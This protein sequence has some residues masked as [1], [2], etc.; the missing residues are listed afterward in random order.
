MNG[1]GVNAMPPSPGDVVRI[2]TR[3][4]LVEDVQGCAGG[5][6]IRGA[7]LDDD[8]QG[9]TLHAIWEL[10]LDTEILDEDAWKSIGQRGFDSPRYFGAY[11]HTLRWN[12]VTATNPRLFQAPFRA[13]IRIDAYQLDPLRKALLLPRVNLFIADDVG[14]GKTIEAGL[15]ASE[16]LLRRRVRDIV[17]SC[18]PSMLLQWKD[19]LES[20]FG[21]TFEVLD[22]KYLEKVRQERG[23]GVNPWTTFPRFLISQRLLIDETYVAPLRDWLDNFRPGSLLILD[24]AHHAAPSSGAKYAIDSRITRAVRDLAPRF[25][26]R[27]FLS[28]TPHNGHSNSFS[29][30]LEI[31]DS[32]RF[33]RGV[34]VLK[35]NL[36]SVMVRRLKEDVREVAGG[37]PKRNVVQVDL[38]KDQVPDDAPELVLPKLL[39][40]YRLV[41]QQ[42]MEGASKRKQAEAGLLI[43]GLQQR[44][45]SSVEA[46]TKTL[47]VH[48]RTM[49]RLWTQD[50]TTQNSRVTTA[51]G[52]TDLKQLTLLTES[53]SSDD[54]LSQLGEQDLEALE[55]EQFEAATVSTAGD[56][57]RA[58]VKAEKELLDKMLAVA[59]Q[60]RGLPDARIRYLVEWIREHMCPGVHLPGERPPSDNPR[61]NDL[62]LLIFTEWEDTKRYLVNMLR[63]AVTGTDLEEHRIEIFHGP[64]PPKKREKIKRAFN[65]PP[66][67]HPVRILVATDAAREGLNLQAH[68]HHLFHFDVPWNP[69]RLE[70][71]NGRIDRK[72]QPAPEVFCHYFVY[73]QR[74]E[75]R[76]LQVLVRKTKTI[77]EELGSLSEVLEAR[78]ADML[79]GGIHHNQVQRLADEIDKADLDSE[80]RATTEEELDVT[81][82]RQD[83]L[84][85]QIAQLDRRVAEARKWIGLD[86][87]SLRDA[88]SCSLEMLGAE[89]LQSQKSPKG[90]PARFVFPNLDTR[91]GGDP[92]WATTLDTLRALPLDDESEFQWRKKAPIRPVVF[93]APQG[94]DDS[95]VQLHLHHRVVQR[96]LGRF[97]SQGFVHHDLSRACLAQ[98]QDNIPRV[99]L[100]GRIS[101][102]GPGAT[103]LHEELLSVTARWSDA[104]TRKDALAPY[105]REAEAKTMDLL[106]QALRPSAQRELPG[107]VSKRRLASIPDDME[108]LLPFLNKWGNAARFDAEKA[109]TERG[110]AEAKEMRRIL[111]EQKKRILS[112]LGKSIDQQLTLFTTD[113]ERRQYGSNRRYWERWIENVEGDLEREPARIMDFYKVTSY[114]IEPVGIAY[115]CP[116]TE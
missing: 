65:A 83:E 53:P 2:R 90:E 68:C 22:R 8:A 42:R 105:A 44:L 98:S 61:W 102:Y 48:R 19:E 14:L 93:E 26:H 72:L 12:C 96:L 77:R 58:D 62:R 56:A 36:D 40:Q 10:E 63:A 107:S 106:E 16:L 11:M 29:A 27:L 112:E 4:Y 95:V 99:I 87:E 109:L 64:T 92:S 88:L 67:K 81:R 45:L 38:G 17:V 51:S 108:Q 59:E 101:L 5:H 66:S 15:I 80:K 54:E 76:V 24:E 71:R 32:Q 85:K 55:H 25:E 31:L 60:A 30:L 79:K 47:R 69:S 97:L 52:K 13:G 94:I 3:T 50:A 113:E 37:F 84:R 41:R 73:T 9:Q 39:D 28:A 49:E 23:F 104:A 35:S 103:R 1:A 110:Q 20:R 82:Q 115:L 100:L 46:F 74:P 111:E 91:Q 75:D 78:L 7:C 114:R 43:S 57:A 89:P 70:Q 34:K 21:L 18:P 6:T 33:C 86:M 116:A